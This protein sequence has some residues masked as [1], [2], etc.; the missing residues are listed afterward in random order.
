MKKSSP[1]KDFKRTCEF[2][3]ANSQA[4]PQFLSEGWRLC[5]MTGRR[6]SILKAEEQGTFLAHRAALCPMRGL[7]AA[8]EQ[9]TPYSKKSTSPAAITKATIQKRV[10]KEKS[11][12]S[13]VRAGAHLRPIWSSTHLGR[14]W[15]KR[16][17]QPDIYHNRRQ[18]CKPNFLDI[19]S[20]ISQILHS[21]P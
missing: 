6:F 10:T 3:K 20:S 15:S 17:G 7:G 9:P 21:P 4:S 14:Q 1:K 8:G 18:P 2:Y 13:L 5:Q 19:S 12:N 11:Q 16:R